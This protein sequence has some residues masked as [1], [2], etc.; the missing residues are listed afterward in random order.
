MQ[1]YAAFL[2][3]VSPMNLKMPELAKAF[4]DAGFSHVKTLLSSGNVV[5]RAP[6][7]SDAGLQRRAE[8]AM[9]AALGKSFM[10][11][12]RPIEHLQTLLDADPYAALKLPAE[13]KRVVTFLHEP[14]QDMPPLPIE[15]NGARLL[16]WKDREL[17]S[18]YVPTRNDPVFMRL[19]ERHCGK[20]QTTRTWD[21]VRKVVAVGGA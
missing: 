21:T 2:R 10:T 17:F 12:V 1:R 20:A 6:R 16:A 9:R 11:F 19:I 5:F 8:A 14:P 7:A 15:L 18:A 3:G 4:A 13:C